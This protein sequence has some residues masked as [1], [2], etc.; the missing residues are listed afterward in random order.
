MEERFSDDFTLDIV[1]APEDMDENGHVSNLVYLRWVQD[2]AR[3]HSESLGWD[4]A[5]YMRVGAAFFVRRHEIDYLAAAVAGDRLRAL[6]WISGWSA[7]TT[8]RHTRLIRASDDKELAR[9][10]TTWAFVSMTGR[11]RRILPE[12]VESFR[13]K[14]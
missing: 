10:K 4:H 3:A 9:C 14:S 11:P 5:A 7:A 12:V 8:I 6:T 1:A 2:A 13:K